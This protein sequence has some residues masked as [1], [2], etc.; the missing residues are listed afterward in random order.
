MTLEFWPKAYSSSTGFYRKETTKLAKGGSFMRTKVKIRIIFEKGIRKKTV[1]KPG[2]S[3][4]VSS[5]TE[6]PVRLLET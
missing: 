3:K 4:P 6:E 2:L 1:Q 5:C